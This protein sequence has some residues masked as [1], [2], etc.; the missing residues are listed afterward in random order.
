MEGQT[1]ASDGTDRLPR[2]DAIREGA[3][4]FLSTQHLGISSEKRRQCS[5]DFCFEVEPKVKQN[6]QRYLYILSLN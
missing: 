1:E 6:I 3:A 2:S 5:M 4:G